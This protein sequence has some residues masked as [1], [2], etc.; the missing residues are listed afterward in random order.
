MRTDLSLSAPRAVGVLP[1]HPCHLCH[2]DYPLHR[3][4]GP[5]PA[6]SCGNGSASPQS[7][8]CP[9]GGA[10]KCGGACRHRRHNGSRS[11]KAPERMWRAVESRASRLAP[12]ELQR[13]PYP[14]AQCTRQ[15]SGLVDQPDLL[16]YVLYLKVLGKIRTAEPLV[17]AVLDEI[18]GVAMLFGHTLLI[19]KQC[20][21]EV[22]RLACTVSVKRLGPELLPVLVEPRPTAC[23]LP[24]RERDRHETPIARCVVGQA[25]QVV[26]GAHDDRP[27]RERL[28]VAPIREPDPAV[29]GT[30]HK[31]LEPGEICARGPRH[32]RAFHDHPALQRLHAFL[33][34]TAQAEYVTEPRVLLNGRKEEP[35]RGGLADALRSDKHD[36]DVVLVAGL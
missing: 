30:G 16:R 11:T 35:K 2:L 12:T 23:H 7:A 8:S 34:A 5:V 20:V 29:V 17:D 19:R 1:C 28:W 22:R 14:H 15:S 32:L 6:R 4:T 33:G 24:G 9:P 21:E 3:E 36:H 27:A 31:R 26:R 13:G 18:V 10:G 25:R